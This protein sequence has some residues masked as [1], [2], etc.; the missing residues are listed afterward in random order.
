MSA[1]TAR[2]AWTV[3]ILASTDPRLY[4]SAKMLARLLRW[5]PEG[6]ARPVLVVAEPVPLADVAR[7]LG[8]AVEVIPGITLADGPA[9]YVRAVGRLRA[10][11]KARRARVVLAQNRR[12]LMA[13]LPVAVPLGLGRVWQIGLGFDSRANRW[14]NRVG[15][16]FAD[17]VCLESSHQADT[18][19]GRGW[20]RRF[21][22]RLRV[23]PKGIDVTGAPPGTAGAAGAG[24]FRIGTLASITRR[25]AIDVL[26]EA[27]DGLA[28]TVTAITI[29]GEPVSA[30]DARYLAELEAYVAAHPALPPTHFPGF[31]ADVGAFYAS[32]DAFVLP[33]R[34]E[35]I[36]GAVREAMLAGTPVIATDVG[37]MRTL[38]EHGTTGLLVPAG[39]PAAL[40]QAIVR[41]AG[42]PALR[43][44]LAA[45]ARER[46]ERE[47]DPA[48]FAA[49]YH[50]VF[51]ELGR[52]GADHTL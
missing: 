51:M 42:D 31:V 38:I 15:L 1:E 24:G 33:S 52:E 10:V 47:Y 50:A 39:D 20:L 48:A 6:P 30:D 2:G 8:V 41:L 25:K 40:R 13:A 22:R 29:G 4:G 7:S 35:G 34:N 36:S 45:A 44:A 28:G 23:I 49:R 46:V 32:L 21:P 27:C 3:V 17:V 26:L 18:N 16:L 9:A 43:L 5:W 14:A 37:G 11:A 19:F 12:L